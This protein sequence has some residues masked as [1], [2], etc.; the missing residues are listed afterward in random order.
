MEKAVRLTAQFYVTLELPAERDPVPIAIAALRSLILVHRHEY[1]PTAFE[2]REVKEERNPDDERGRGD[3]PVPTK[4]LTG[5]DL[6]Q[7]LLNW[8]RR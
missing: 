8:W 6:W 5:N 4:W 7:H 2:L 3:A 1:T